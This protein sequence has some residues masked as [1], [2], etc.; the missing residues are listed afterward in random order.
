[1]L[2]I[3]QKFMVHQWIGWSPNN[4]SDEEIEQRH[5]ESEL[6]PMTPF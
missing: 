2:G 5:N 1:M 6:P 4:L 3:L